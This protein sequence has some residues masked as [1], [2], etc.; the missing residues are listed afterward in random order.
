MKSIKEWEDKPVKVSELLKKVERQ[1]HSIVPNAD[2]IL[3]GS[4]VRGEAG[5]FSDW[6]FLILTDQLVDRNLTIKLR[7]SLY[8]IEL[9]TDEILS[10][11]I[12]TRQDWHSPRY[13]V[14]PFKRIVEKEGVVL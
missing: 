5:K 3:Y 2:V 10:S 13:S 6:D 8:E 12:R 7:D 9:E 14:L 1:I 11:I 4:R